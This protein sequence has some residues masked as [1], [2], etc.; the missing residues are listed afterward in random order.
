VTEVLKKF[1]MT[2]N[3]KA[4]PSHR[5]FEVVSPVT[6]EVYAEAPDCT[7]EQLDEAME[8]A[9]RAFPQW[10]KDDA[11]RIQVLHDMACA[12]EA[13]AEEIARCQTMEQGRPF[14]KSVEGVKAAARHFLHYAELEIPREVLQNDDEAF[15]ELVRRPLG[16]VAVIKPWNSPAVNVLHVLGPVIRIGNTAVLKPSPFTPTSALA[17][18]EVLRDVVPPGVVNI[19]T[20]GDSLGQWMVEHPIPRGVAFTGSSETGRL[21]NRSASPDLKRCLLELGGNDPAIVLDDVDPE[22][23]AEKVFWTAFVNSGQICAAVKRVY[24]HESIYEEFANALAKIANSVKVGDVFDKGTDL[25]PLT[26]KP[27]FDRVKEL[28]DD[29]LAKGA[30]ALAGGHPIDGEGFFFAPTILTGVKEGF[31]IVDEEQFGPALPVMSYTT[32]DE[33]VERANSTPYGLGASVWARD[34]ERAAAVAERIESGMVWINSHAPESKDN[35][36]FGGVKG[37]GL[38]T[39][40]GIYSIYAFSDPQAVTR[41]Y[42]GGTT[43]RPS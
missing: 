41:S 19:I 12:V 8:S 15:T 20:G 30:T 34:L 33:A 26:N 31:R 38:G 43:Y 42:Q 22:Q 9:E 16:V 28:V 4:A 27:Q 39:Q 37:S 5:T 6:G 13:H 36:P 14:H 7:R 32:I 29:A 11:F 21:V 1:T 3:G 17:I 18:G 25:G 24:V 23:V 35:A 40:N 10:R 2:I